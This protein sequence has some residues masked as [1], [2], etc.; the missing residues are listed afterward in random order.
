MRHSGRLAVDADD[1]ALTHGQL[2]ARANQLARYLLAQGA[3][4]GDRIGLLFDHAVHSYLGML[5][6]LKINAAYVPLDVGFPADR[7]SFIVGDADAGMVV[8]LGHLRDRV[9]H[10]PVTLLCVD[11]AAAQISACPD[12]R[13]TAAERGEPVDELAYVVYTSG[14]TG[15]PKGV[16]VEHASIC[17]FVRVAAEVYGIQPRDRVYQGMTIAFD[18]SVEEIWVPL[19]VGATLVPKPSGSSLLGDE[20]HAFI[21]AKQITALCCV[22]TLLATLDEDLPGLRFLLVSGEACPQDLIT[23]WHR[24]DRRFLNVYGPTEATVTATWTSVHPDRPVTIGVALPTYSTVILD[25]AGEQRVLAPGEVG[26]IGIAGIGLARGYLNRD[27]LTDRVFIRD[28]IGIPNNPSGRIYRTGDLGRI[29]GGG[30][31][32]YHGRIDTQ[33]KIRGYRIELTEIESVLLQV[34]GIAQAVVDTYEPEPGTVEL[35]AYYSPRAGTADVDQQQIYEYLRRRL[36]RYMVP[37]YLEELAVIP[38][39]PSDKADRHNLPTPT[40]RRGTVEQHPHVIAA[41]ATESFLAD[42][43]AGVLRLEQVSVDSHFFDDLGASSLLMAQFCAQVRTRTDLPPVSMKDVY[44]QPTI[45]SL[46]AQL[47]EMAP[48]A[49][50]MPAATVPQ[51]KPDTV[52]S[53]SPVLCGAL[54]LLLFLAGISVGALVF[55]TGFE[56]IR[57][58]SEL[59]DTYL[60]SLVFGCVTVL[61]TCTVSILAKWALIGRWT[62][63]EIHV[64]SLAYVRFWLVKTLIRTNP[65]VLFVGSPLYVLYL[66]ALGARIGR[67]V[68]IFSAT[69]PVC[70]DLLTIGDGTVIRKDSSFTCYRAH[71][72][73]IQTGPVTLGKEV[74]VG[75]ETTLDIQTSMGDR[76]QIGHASSLHAGQAVPQGQSWHGSPARRTDVNYQTVAAARCGTP[77]RVLYSLGQALTGLLLAAPLA[78]AIVVTLA[79][80]VPLLAGLLGPGQSLATWTFYRDALVISLVLFFGIMLFGLAV[81]ATI[82]RLLS[83]AI[84]AD[85]VYPLYGLHYWIQGMI[86]RLTNSKFYLRLFGDSSYIVG[87][88]RYLGYDLARVEQTGSNVGNELKHDSPYLSF[89]GT[90]TML[91]DGVSIN[92][93]DYSSTSFQVSHVS[94]GSRSFFGNNIAYPSQGRTGDNCLLATK[95]MVPIDGEVRE[96]VGL[97][98][99]PP[100]EIPRSVHS[101]C[102]VPGAVSAAKLP[103]ALAAKNRYNLA[104]IGWYLG[105]QW[106]RFLAAVLLTLTAVDLYDQLR[107]TVIPLAVVAGLLFNVSYSVLVER[108]ISGFRPLSPQSCSIYDPY[109]WWHERLWKLEAAVPF[110]GTPFKSLIWRLLG[111]RI[112]RGVFDDGCYIPEKTLVAIGDGCTLNASSVIQCHSQEEGIFKSDHTTIGAG[113]TV[114]VNAFIHYGV[115]MGDRAVLDADSFL[116]KGEQIAPDT[117]WHGNP[118]REIRAA[119]QIRPAREIRPAGERNVDPVRPRL[120]TSAITALVR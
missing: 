77:R 43:L 21:H 3:R 9:G 53:A 64:W 120:A 86:G 57:A 29:N 16:A 32:E 1:T 44:L 42:A 88:L 75:E 87:Y 55:V 72:G 19:I 119:H 5:A 91:S 117:R 31:I 82:P 20:L 7:V 110:S 112:G 98:G 74:I 10:L 63:H 17:N 13:L 95:A 34:P 25:P 108:A 38:A 46:A 106:I 23:R 79:I 76:A 36:P 48:A 22:P 96:G 61:A 37:A 68:A 8:S 69:V 24:P 70:T 12:Q 47:E 116:M 103:H 62:P 85:R 65:L 100:F 104:T 27:D 97:L 26:E 59:I 89:V 114:G 51:A 45:H 6:V 83:L 92:N 118:A 105:M 11:E 39:L 18:F 80:K 115:T 4:P 94:L 101:A 66:K 67:G 54:Q 2:D 49:A 113:C 78:L 40:G 109:Y 58:A 107:F 71:A 52:A 60:R 14:S 30:E 81:V 111:V 102:P 73:R 93:A 33:V 28:F 90:G 50:P 84:T 56:W 35:V 15:R 41:T 99:S